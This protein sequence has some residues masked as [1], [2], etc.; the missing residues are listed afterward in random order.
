MNTEKNKLTWQKIRE[1][2]T[3]IMDGKVPVPEMA[4]GSESN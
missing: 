3:Q 2:S 1:K 4:A